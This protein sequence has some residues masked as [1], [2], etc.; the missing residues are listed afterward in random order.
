MAEPMSLAASIAALGGLLVT[1]VRFAH[2]MSGYYE[3]LLRYHMIL[4]IIQRTTSTILYVSA[5]SESARS[6]EFT[7]KGKKESLIPFCT[8]SVE[9]LASDVRRLTATLKTAYDKKSREARATRSYLRRITGA[10]TRT[11]SKFQFALNRRHIQDLIQRAKHIESSLYFAQSTLLL[12]WNEA[13]TTETQELL[14]GLQNSFLTYTN[15]FESFRESLERRNPAVIY[16]NDECESQS[17]QSAGE[18]ESNRLQIERDT[19]NFLS[20]ISPHSTQSA[21]LTLGENVSQTLASIRYDRT[22]QRPQH[23]LRFSGSAQH[24]LTEAEDADKLSSDMPCEQAEEDYI[25]SDSEYFPMTT[26][27][28]GPSLQT[29]THDNSELD[30]DPNAETFIDG[31]VQ[32]ANCVSL[33]DPDCFEFCTRTMLVHDT[34]PTVFVLKE[35]CNSTLCRHISICVRGSLSSDL[36]TPCFY[37]AFLQEQQDP[38][39]PLDTSNSDTEY[40][41]LFTAQH[42]AMRSHATLILSQSG[43]LKQYALRTSLFATLSPLPDEEDQET[44]HSETS[45]E[46]ILVTEGVQQGQEEESSVQSEEPVPAGIPPYSSLPCYFC[47][48]DALR[49]RLSAGGIQALLLLKNRSFGYTCERCKDRTWVSATSYGLTGVGASWGFW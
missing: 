29:V 3:D 48:Q 5:R 31:S 17:A 35:R 14:N 15:Q 28:E 42:C 21:D 23:L 26:D 25:F 6:I 47:R 16:I 8:R 18:T 30:L 45:P 2:E 43:R 12:S 44:E 49:P 37:R 19:H 40:I 4:E 24:L 39:S 46:R 13:R 36:Q 34:E 9:S 41:R 11:S 38:Q 27:D 22:L 7:I 10:L 1:I 33:E 32:M 20:A